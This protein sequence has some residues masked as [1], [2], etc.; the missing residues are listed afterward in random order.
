[1]GGKVLVCTSAKN[2]FKSPERLN[3]ENVDCPK[4]C[5]CLFTLYEFRVGTNWC[6]LVGRKTECG[7][8]QW[9][10]DSPVTHR[11]LQRWPEWKAS[12]WKNLQ[13]ISFRCKSAQP[14]STPRGWRMPRKSKSFCLLY[15][16]ATFLILF[17]I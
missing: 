4:I 11:G 14:R 9:E 2:T 6:S 12:F 3:V 13:L 10:A 5:R 15:I 17:I 1:M 7:N 8:N 16:K